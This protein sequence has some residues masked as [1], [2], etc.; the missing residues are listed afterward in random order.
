MRTIHYFLLIDFLNLFRLYPVDKRR[1][2]EYG[3][4]FEKGD[5]ESKK[6]Q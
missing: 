4:A 2:N 5:G 3:Q 6:T 1:V